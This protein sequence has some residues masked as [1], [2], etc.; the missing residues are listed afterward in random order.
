MQYSHIHIANI[1]LIN[2]AKVGYLSTNGING[3]PQSRA[4]INLRN[5]VMFKH[6]VPFFKQHD[7]DMTSYFHANNRSN[8]I[9]QLTR[10]T[11]SS[12]Y[13]SDF[14]TAHGLLITGHLTAVT[15]KAIK[16]TFW[17]DKWID[18]YPDGVDGSQYALLK[19]TPNRACGWFEHKD[20]EY[21]LP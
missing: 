15:D 4:M 9:E 5:G 19:L 11:K 18:F 13:Y 14:E 12:V 1:R 7:N 2:S 20:F 21:I 6:I 10:D 3:Y 17:Q 16:H 8:K